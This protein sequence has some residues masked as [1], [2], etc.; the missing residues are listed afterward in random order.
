MPIYQYTCPECGL[1][2]AM[3]PV[4]TRLTAL[5]PQCH[6]PGVLQISLPSRLAP[7][8]YHDDG[9]GAHVTSRDQR[10]R[11]MKAAGV[12]EVGSTTREGATGTLWSLPGQVATSARPSG[13]YAK[14][15][16]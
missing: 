9:L 14:G 11:L 15:S 3:K 16:R 5:C 2:E 8:D 4:E 13:A 6:E 7:L 1:Y 10:R 12:E